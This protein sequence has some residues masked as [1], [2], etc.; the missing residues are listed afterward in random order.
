M[1]INS[2]IFA[3][4]SRNSE[5]MLFLIMQY[6]AVIDTYNCHTKILVVND[7]VRGEWWMMRW[8]VSGEWWGLSGKWWD[9][10]WVVNDEVKGEWW[11][12]RGERWLMRWGVSGEKGGVSCEWWG[13]GLVVNDEGWAVNDEGWVVNYEGWAVNGEW[14]LWN[15]RVWGSFNSTT[16]NCLFGQ[17]ASRFFI[18]SRK[19]QNC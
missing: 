9:G 17:V 19:T 10:G 6:I 1:K 12:T 13:D 2:L 14:W 4:F 15:M 5:K 11:M 8:G 7:E 3:K 18:K 16:K